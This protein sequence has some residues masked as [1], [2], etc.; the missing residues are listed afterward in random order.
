V[1]ALDAEG[2]LDDLGGGHGR[3]MIASGMIHPDGAPK[4]GAAAPAANV[5]IGAVHVS[6]RP[7]SSAG[8]LP[9]E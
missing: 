6:N 9:G 2:V 3:A 7:A 8:R 4:T 5:T 1:V